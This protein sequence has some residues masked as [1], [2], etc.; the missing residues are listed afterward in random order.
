[1]DSRITEIE[2]RLDKTPDT[3]HDIWYLQQKIIDL[4]DHSRRNNLRI[5]GLPE[6]IEK[7]DILE[8]LTNLIPTLMNITFTVPLEFQRAHRVR[9]V[10]QI[11][12]QILGIF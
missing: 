1:M 8:F 12:L 2:S 11:A 7:D 5:I 10:H 4:E 6:Q 9:S 3:S